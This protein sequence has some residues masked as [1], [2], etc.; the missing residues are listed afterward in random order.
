MS[1]G[2]GYLVAGG[3]CSERIHLP[4]AAWALERCCHSY[5]ACVHHALGLRGPAVLTQTSAARSWALNWTAHLLSQQRSLF[6]KG[7]ETDICRYVQQ[8]LLPSSTFEASWCRT[9]SW[10]NGWMGTSLWALHLRFKRTT[11]RT[12]RPTPG[13]KTQW[14]VKK[15]TSLCH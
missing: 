4:P 2:I 15:G 3:C 14:M 9:S 7:G 11:V 6:R 10:A 13:Q 5:L 12:S 8:L 1:R